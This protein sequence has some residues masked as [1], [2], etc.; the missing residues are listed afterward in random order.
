M[1]VHRGPYLRALHQIT[2]DFEQDHDMKTLMFWEVI[3]EMC[4][5]LESQ[6]I[7]NDVQ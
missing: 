5:Y 3:L 1:G 6:E 7:R 2:E 4:E